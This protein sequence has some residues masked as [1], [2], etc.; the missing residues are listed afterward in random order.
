MRLFLFGLLFGLSGCLY[1]VSHPSQ[2]HVIPVWVDP[3]FT[4]AERSDIRGAFAEW[5]FTLADVGVLYQPG[6]RV[7]EARVFVIRT[8][9]DD[10]EI[11]ETEPGQQVLAWASGTNIHVVSDRMRLG[12]LHPVMIHEMGHIQ[13]IGHINAPKCIMQPQFSYG[14]D[15][16]DKYT[17]F[18]YSEIHGV[19]L[20][21]LNYCE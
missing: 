20:K 17:A 12:M 11:P 3:T 19:P 5:S 21:L 8:T 6:A 13:G 2:E 1:N 14:V 16:V 9:S 18:A 15:C 7:G 10:N 4:D